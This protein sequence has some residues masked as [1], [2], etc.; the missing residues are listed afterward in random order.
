MENA[1]DIIKKVNEKDFNELWNRMDAD[2]LIWEMEPSGEEVIK[3]KTEAHPTDI[4]FPTNDIRTFCDDVQSTLASARMTIKVGMAE[5]EGEDKRDEMGQLERLFY[6]LLFKGDE[7]LRRLLLPPLREQL[8]WQ[9]I[10]RGWI[11]ARFLTYSDKSGNV[12]TDYMAYDPRWLK[13]EVGSTGLLWTSHETFK[14][15]ADLESTYKYK[16]GNEK[17]NSVIDYWERVGEGTF[18]NAII[19]KDTF[20]RKRT[21]RMKSHPVLIMP[22]STRPPIAGIGEMRVKGYGDCIFA[23]VRKVNAVRNRFLSMWATHANKLAHQPLINYRTDDGEDIDDMTN[24]ASG[25]MNLPMNE[26]RVEESPMKEVSPTVV[27]MSDELNRQM[28]QGMLTRHPRESPI[29]SGTRYAL[30]QEQGNKVYNPQLRNLNNFYADACR[31]IEEQLLAG[32]IGGKKITSVN[33]QWQEKNKYFETKVTPVDLK[34]PHTIEVEFTARSPW[35]QMDV[36]QQAQ[37]LRDLEIPQG[38]INENIL[39]IQD[40]KM[41]ADLAAIE[42]YEKSPEGAMSTAAEALVRLRGDVFRAG[43]IMEKLD[44]LA[45][46]EKMAMEQQAVSPEQPPGGGI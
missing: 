14:S 33:V 21:Y 10:V 42:L 40:P 19:H 32:G 17:D 41:L 22:V 15:G 39:K 24:K 26:N 8:I 11:S 2:F 27:G 1:A 36:V 20:L 23:S 38:W 31:L 29:S 13:Y 37:M 5:A 16:D 44:M 4:E 6:F 18:T 43:K 3:A 25:V 45:A 12:I 34:K 35:E 30:E 9:D 46:Q 28:G 7:R